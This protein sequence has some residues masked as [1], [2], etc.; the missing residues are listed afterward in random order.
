MKTNVIS[1]PNKR[2]SPIDSVFFGKD[3]IKV[4][5]RLQYWGV[6]N[7]GVIWR[8]DNIVSYKRKQGNYRYNR[9]NV[10]AP[11]YMHDE[12]HMSANGVR[13]VVQFSYIR[14]SAIWWKV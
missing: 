1:L 6:R 13:R 3:D 4:G 5:S 11:R 8:V 12:I 7:P 10:P 14:Y 9:L 2:L